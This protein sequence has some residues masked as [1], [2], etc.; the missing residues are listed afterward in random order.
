MN[1]HIS[2]TSAN[3]RRNSRNADWILFNHRRGIDYVIDGIFSVDEDPRFPASI[4]EKN[5]NIMKR[6]LEV[7]KEKIEI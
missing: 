6:K 4:C 2:H 7:Q 3:D 1:H 5:G